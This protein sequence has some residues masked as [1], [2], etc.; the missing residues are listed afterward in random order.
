M[1]FS[2]LVAKRRISQGVQPSFFE[3]WAPVLADSIAVVTVLAMILAPIFAPV[4]DGAE[5]LS[6]SGI[7]I[8]VAVYV[9]FQAVLIVSA[10]W[11]VRSRWSDEGE[12]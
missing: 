3:A 12:G 2:R 9:V 6:S 8:L 5:T 4:I 7:M 1:I 11:A 10:I